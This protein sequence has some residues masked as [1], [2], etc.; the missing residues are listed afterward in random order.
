MAFSS[1]ND[2]CILFL[3]VCWAAE[4]VLTHRLQGNHADISSGNVTNGE[5]SGAKPLDM[6]IVFATDCSSHQKW[7]SY[8]FLHSASSV[9]QKGPITWMRANCALTGKPTATADDLNMLQ[10]LYLEASLIDFEVNE[11]LPDKS[12]V[13]PFALQRFVDLHRDMPENRL[14]AFVDGDMIFLSRF[15]ID[16]LDQRSLAFNG[17]G[18]LTRQNGN[19]VGPNVGV[20]QRYLCCD[21]SGAPYVFWLSAWRKLLPHWIAERSKASGT[22]WGEE[23]HAFATAIRAAG[24]K[25]NVFEHFMLSVPFRNHSNDGEGEGWPWVDEAIAQLGGD[26]CSS[27]VPGENG[28]VRKLPTFLHVCQAWSAGTDWH[29]SKHNVPPGRERPEGT[30]GILECSMPLLAAPPA[31]L[32]RKATALYKR[33]AWGICTIYHSLNG[34]LLKHKQQRCPAGFNSAKILKIGNNDKN[35]LIE[36]PSP[37]IIGNVS[38]K[39]VERCAGNVDCKPWKDVV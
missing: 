18:H 13:K 4:K 36:D 19:L 16:D 22:W 39:W 10:S 6:H 24:L 11:R 8:L 37:H 28:E 15:R 33:N 2:S 30:D 7:M 32:M 25:F 35:R 5:Q 21:N 26:V 31:D 1:R 14:V 12:W 3:V 34:M 23:Q 17:P 20:V 29:Y 27:G 9:G 38:P